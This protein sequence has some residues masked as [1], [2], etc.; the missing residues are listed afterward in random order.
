V[1]SGVIIPFDNEK[2]HKLALIVNVF[3]EYFSLKKN[4]KNL[5]R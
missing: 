2:I 4:K 3:K 5:M 1:T